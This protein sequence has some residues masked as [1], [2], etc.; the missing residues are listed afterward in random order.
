LRRGDWKIVADA[1]GEWQLYNLGVDR[2]EC[3]NLAEVQP[4]IVAELANRWQELTDEMERR[5]YPAAA[6]R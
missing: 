3:R 1:E 2:T 5:R 4:E 6:S